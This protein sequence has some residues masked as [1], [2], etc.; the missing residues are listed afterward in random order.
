MKFNRKPSIFDDRSGI[1]SSD[2]LDEYGVWV[3]SEPED[4][5]AGAEDESFAVEETGALPAE[6]DAPAD[7]SFEFDDFAQE[8]GGEA[9]DAAGEAADGGAAFA[10]SDDFSVESLD[11][12]EA[13]ASFEGA[14]DGPFP[15]GAIDI[16]LDDDFDA[17]S[18]AEEPL[19]EIPALDDEGALPDEVSLDD[20][21]FE[22]EALEK[23]AKEED[24]IALDDGAFEDDL[25]LSGDDALEEMVP[26]EAALEEAPVAGTGAAAGDGGV[27]TELLLKIA[28]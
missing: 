24:E 7:D 15:A 14:D 23:A 16:S 1:G 13:F 22:E 19:A 8:S 20:M 5:L 17:E 4:L 9:A 12:D 6:H 26:E 25:A 10:G 3:K 21:S 11:G 18:G 28:N 27:A 2:E